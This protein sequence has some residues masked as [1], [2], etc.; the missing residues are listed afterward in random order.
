VFYAWVTEYPD[1]AEARRNLFLTQ[2]DVPAV[3]VYDEG[4]G[5]AGMNGETIVEE[6][7]YW[8]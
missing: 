6:R 4:K 7:P 5:W 1:E 2:M 8:E 3:L